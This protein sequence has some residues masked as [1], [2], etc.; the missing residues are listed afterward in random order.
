MWALFVVLIG[1]GI[2]ANALWSSG[3]SYREYHQIST[4]NLGFVLISLFV[5]CSA[6]WYR[7][8]LFQKAVPPFL[9][10]ALLSSS[11]L[12]IPP[13]IYNLEKMPIIGCVLFLLPWTF[14]AIAAVLADRKRLYDLAVLIIGGRFVVVYFEVFG[15]LT[16]T[17]FGLIISGSIILLTVYCWHRYRANIATLIREQI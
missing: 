15:S 11:L 9:I 5:C 3:I 12:L 8:K 7:R 13:L 17:G 10:A 1:G 6:I 4:G 14:T 16:A 2:Y